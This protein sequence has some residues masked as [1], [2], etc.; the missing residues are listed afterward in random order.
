MSREGSP[1]CFREGELV[2]IRKL[3][4]ED[5]DDRYTRWV[6]DQEVTEFMRT[7]TFPSDM[8]DVRNYV[9]EKNE[10]DD[11]L[12]LAI[13]TTEDHTHVGNIKLGP[14]DW[15]YRR[16]ELSIMIGEKDYWGQG[17]G[18]DAIRL[19]AEYAFNKL[20]LHK[21]F[22]GCYSNNQGMIGAFENA[23]FEKEGRLVDHGFHR[24]QYTDI[25]RFGRIEPDEAQEE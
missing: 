1:L 19:T 3:R 4:E 15:I 21:V 22:A 14:I 6:N 7:G 13:V 2:Y 25:I 20:N 12:M 16:A 23:G 8:D 11:I 9:S 24:G 10:A 5:V 17:I 18:T